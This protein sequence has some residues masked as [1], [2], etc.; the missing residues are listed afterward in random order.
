M[1]PAR[2]RVLEWVRDN[3]NHLGLRDT[4]EPS[5][6]TLRKLEDAEIIDLSG[7]RFGGARWR[8]TDLGKKMLEE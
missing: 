6:A 1:H 4:G 8:L 3:G 2:R 5:I 7:S